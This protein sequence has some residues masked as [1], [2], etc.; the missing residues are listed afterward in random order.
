MRSLGCPK[1]SVHP[2]LLLAAR[3][4]SMRFNGTFSEERL[5]AAIRARR[6]GVQFRRQVPVG[7][8]YIVDFL[9]PERRLVVEVDGGYHARTQPADA[10]R[11]EAL[12]RLGYRVLRLEAKL[13]ERDLSVAVARIRQELG[14]LVG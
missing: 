11:D 12:R 5:W 14:R 3:A 9:A 7:G 6:L 2:A 1:R 8:R 4:R 13:V 10:R